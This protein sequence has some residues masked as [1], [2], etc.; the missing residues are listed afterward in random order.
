MLFSFVIPQ[1]AEAMMTNSTVINSISG[2]ATEIPQDT[3]LS[4]ALNFLSPTWHLRHIGRQLLEVAPGSV[5]ISPVALIGHGL[6]TL[7]ALL[8]PSIIFMAAG[9]AIFL[10]N[11]TLTLE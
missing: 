7:L 5:I 1:M 9:Y 10:R 8:T 3:A 4:Q 2:T 6:T 11:E